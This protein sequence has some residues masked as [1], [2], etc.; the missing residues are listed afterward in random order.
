MNNP[1]SLRDLPATVVDLL[2]LSDGSPFPGHSLAAYWA[3]SAGEDSEITTPALSEQV[4]ATAFQAQPGSD[5]GHVDFQMSLVTA[6][7]HFVRSGLGAEQLYDLSRDPYERNDLMLSPDGN[8]QV[9]V[10]RKKLLEVLTENRG[11]VEAEASY[12]RDYRKSLEA[13]LR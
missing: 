10:F 9:A 4:D 2:G 5:G 13:L 12:L 3:D 11:S 6:G 8:R 1:V 7:H